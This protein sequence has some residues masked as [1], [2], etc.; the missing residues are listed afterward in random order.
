MSAASRVR[1]AV[2][3]LL[4][5]QGIELVDVEVRGATLR[6]IVDCDGGI[7][8]DAVAAATQTVSDALDDDE[9][10]EG[11]Y[12]LE[13]SSPGVE[14]PLRLPE[15]FRRAVGSTVAVKTHAGTDGDRRYE[16]V[17]ESADDAGIVVAGETIPYDAIERARTTFEWGPAPKPGKKTKDG[18]RRGRGPRLREEAGVGAP[19][20]RKDKAGQR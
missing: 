19:A 17:L 2:E 16:G 12:V 14:R 9:S 5:P 15:H 3:P 6:V 4:I 11:P 20:G 10:L 1:Q 18:P 8:L 13:V 7:D